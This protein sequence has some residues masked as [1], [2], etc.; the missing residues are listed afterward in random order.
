MLLNNNTFYKS[1]VL[2][3]SIFV[4][5]S[6]YI[7]EP[8][9]SNKFIVEESNQNLSKSN[10]TV[11][12]SGSIPRNSEWEQLNKYVYFRRSAAFYFKDKQLLRIFFI[13]KSNLRH[14]YDFIVTLKPD[15]TETITVVL[16]NAQV[17]LH[18]RWDI[19]EVN[20][21]NY[22]FSVSQ[23]FEMNE[24][25]FKMDLFVKQN[26]PLIQTSHP[27]EVKIKSF[28]GKNKEDAA[29]CSKCYYYN[30]DTSKIFEWWFELNIQIGFNKISI[31]NNTIPNTENFER[32]LK[33][34]ES[35]VHVYQMNFLP[36]YIYNSSALNDNSH[37]YLTDFHDLK[38][39]GKR[40]FL[41]YTNIFD[42]LMFNE[43]YLDNVDKYDYVMV[44]DNDETVIPRS[45]DFSNA[46]KSFEF[47]ANLDF[48]V[49][50]PN[51]INSHLK[52][53]CPSKLT[54][55]FAEMYGKRK[56]TWHFL[57][58]FYI[59]NHEIKHICST[60]Q[61]YFKKNG[62]TNTRNLIN[63][64]D[65][66]KTSS[67]H[68][69]YNYSFLIQGSAEINYAKNLCKLS[70][71]FTE[72]LWPKVAELNIA[73]RFNRLFFMSG[74]TTEFFLG[75]TAHFTESTLQMTHHYAVESNMDMISFDSGHLS[76]FRDIYELK[77]VICSIRELKLDLNYFNCYFPNVIKAL[78]NF[79]LSNL[80]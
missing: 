7:F 40:F 57:M 70:Q 64:I 35:N 61:D 17:K 25:E 67:T 44:I 66:Q 79:S 76:H 51:E 34:Y 71:F 43:C 36:N 2:F 31:C 21:L 52:K 74:Q 28:H 53:S 41:F 20:S 78:A 38:I 58:G 59:K 18:D 50:K 42:I 68:F 19:Y 24:N 39:N 56:K 37:Q 26:N 69:A 1:V 12:S 48:T 16:P 55:N 10:S 54:A 32:I 45:M 47:I 30:D 22:N 33:K 77:K 27:I 62:E 8:F 72:N 4:L 15:Q 65:K 3:I 13:S 6:F 73:E 5:A 60:I 29:I 23:Y 46:Q 63:I 11:N 75:K 14:K 49:L 80:I 9:V